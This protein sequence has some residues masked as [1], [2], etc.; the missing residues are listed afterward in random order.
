MIYQKKFCLKVV[1]FK[2]HSRSLHGI[3]NMNGPFC[4][5]Q[6]MGQKTRCRMTG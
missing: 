4:Q 1:K 3:C 5:L 2:R 6:N